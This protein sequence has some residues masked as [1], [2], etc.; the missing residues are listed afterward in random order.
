MEAGDCEGRL[1]PLFVPEVRDQK[2]EV[3]SQRSGVRGQ[4]SEV[5]S[6]KS[7]FGHDAWLI[8]QSTFE[9]LTLAAIDI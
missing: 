3:R 9:E 7:D 6:Q 2:S 8:C 4:K 5:R 1:P